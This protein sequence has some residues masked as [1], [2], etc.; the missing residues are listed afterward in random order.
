M[1]A[2]GRRVCAVWLA[3][4]VAACGGRGFAAGTVGEATPGMREEIY[5]KYLENP[6]SA[7]WLTVPGTGIDAVV[8]K[9]PRTRDNSFYLT[10][11]FQ[12]E[13]DPDGMFCADYRSEIYGTRDKLS[14]VTAV[15]GHSWDD[16]PDG[17]LFSQLK[18]F[19]DPEFAREHPYIYFS[20][21]YDDMAFEVFAV[22]DTTVHLPYIRPGMSEDTFLTVI[23]MVESLTL[24]HYDTAIDCG[25]KL[26]ALSTCTY[27]A[28]GYPTLPGLNDYRFVVMGKLVEPGEKLKEEAVFE[29][30]ENVL[31]PDATLAFKS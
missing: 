22:F 10:H 26:I 2:I 27:S 20:S 9:N 21:Y 6:Y 25:D 5:A 23:G 18:R 31:S 28:P 7:G 30:N 8:M 19:R 15:Y 29:V 14:R 24:Y 13:P 16:D 12:N 11:N 1:M 3:L 17:A 4:A